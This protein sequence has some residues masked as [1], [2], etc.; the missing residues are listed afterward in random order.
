MMFGW[1]SDASRLNSRASSSRASLTLVPRPA[2][3]APAR[4][5]FSVTTRPV[6][7]SSAR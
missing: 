4:R 3:G 5:R 1:R 6:E 7:R 2:D